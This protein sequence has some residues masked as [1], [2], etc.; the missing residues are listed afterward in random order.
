MLP[1][2]RSKARKQVLNL[3]SVVERGCRSL[4]TTDDCIVIISKYWPLFIFLK[5]QQK[6]MSSQSC[7]VGQ[8]ATKL[9][10]P[11]GLR[12]KCYENYFAP[13]AAVLACSFSFHFTVTNT[14]VLQVFVRSSSRICAGHEPGPQKIQNPAWYVERNSKLDT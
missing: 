12:Q 6:E 1:A 9:N 14:S 13:L 10:S 11:K 3:T 7:K 8:R 2:K 5:G 4:R